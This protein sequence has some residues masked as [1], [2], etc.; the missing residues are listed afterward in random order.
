M[1]GITIGLGEP[2]D[3]PV[4]ERQ[5]QSI[6]LS[7][8]TPNQSCAIIANI[9]INKLISSIYEDAQL[10]ELERTILIKNANRSRAPVEKY[11]MSISSKDAQKLIDQIRY[12]LD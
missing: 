11:L 7:V 9:I 5:L 6:V 2:K 1:M 4:R 10:N 12:Y 3:I 8:P